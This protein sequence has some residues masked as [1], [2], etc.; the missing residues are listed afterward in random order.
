MINKFE[1]RIIISPIGDINESLIEYTGN[2]ISD[3]F[4][5][6]VELKT[7]L[8]DPGFAL[9]TSRKQYHSTKILEELALLSPVKTLKIL[10]VCDI[11]LF[12]PILTHVFGEAQLGGKA[13]IVST[14]RLRDNLPPANPEKAFY[15]RV[16]K[17]AVHELG[18]T[19]NI[20]HCP[21]RTCSMH[22]CHSIKDVDHK[23]DH[24]C[25]YCTVLLEDE[26]KKIKYPSS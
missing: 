23:S 5:F 11:D 24:F 25:R 6:P 3:R 8:V 1:N 19:F 26:K 18:H 20:R 21:D 2:E 22:Y 10:A 9:D 13:C 16:K 7:L 14:Y 4:G 12:I 15:A 17:E